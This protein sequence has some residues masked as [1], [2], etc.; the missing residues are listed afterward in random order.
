MGA[1]KMKLPHK[2]TLTKEL[3]IIVLVKALIIFALWEVFFSHPASD[4]IQTD[5]AVAAHV[6][7]V[8]IAKIK[9][10]KIQ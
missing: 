6:Y 9:G 1:R 4:H 5:A 10:V 2:Y 8:P 7:S 3:W